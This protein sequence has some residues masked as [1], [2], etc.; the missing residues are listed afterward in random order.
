MARRR[1]R[2]S[3]SS[4][5]VLSGK[6]TDCLPATRTDGSLSVT[7]HLACWPSLKKCLDS[8]HFYNTL[9]NYVLSFR[10]HL[11]TISV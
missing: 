4:V 8:V 1:I 2:E 9:L 11:A 7:R 5:S 6:T 10:L 3:S